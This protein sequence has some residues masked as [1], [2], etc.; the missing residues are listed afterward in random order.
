ME[1]EWIIQLLDGEGNY[2]PTVGWSGRDYSNVGWRR[3]GL[4]K[5]GKEVVG[6]IHLWDGEGRNYLTVVWRG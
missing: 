6:T 5:C 4:Y 2:Y 3:D 1:G